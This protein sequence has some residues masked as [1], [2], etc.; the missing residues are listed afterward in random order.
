LG[1]AVWT[2]SL[3]IAASRILSDGRAADPDAGRQPRAAPHPYDVPSARAAAV[4]RR[5]AAVRL[6]RAVRPPR[7]RRWLPPAGLAAVR[8]GGQRGP[9]VEPGP[10]L[11]RGVPYGAEALPLL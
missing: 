11:A 1:R 6:H 4:A 5:A 3:K 8:R 7:R 10:A 9:V 2:I